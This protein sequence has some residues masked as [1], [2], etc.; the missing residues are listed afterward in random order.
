M[1]EEVG[2]CSIPGQHMGE[3]L[4]VPGTDREETVHLYFQMYSPVT[5]KGRAG[6]RQKDKQ[7]FK[8]QPLTCCE[9]K[10]LSPA[11]LPPKNDYPGLTNRKTHKNPN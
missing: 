2:R 1:S 4:Q 9:E 10:G 8:D 7:T 6:K 11:G 5:D 3:M